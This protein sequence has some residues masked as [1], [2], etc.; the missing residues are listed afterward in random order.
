MKGDE[1]IDIVDTGDGQDKDTKK[2]ENPSDC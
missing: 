2:P 1:I